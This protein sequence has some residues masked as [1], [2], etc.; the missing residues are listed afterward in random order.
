MWVY[1]IGAFFNFN[2]NNVIQL[3][4]SEFPRRT[5]RYTSIHSA[6]LKIEI[7]HNTTDRIFLHQNDDDY[8]LAQ[9]FIHKNHLN[10]NLVQHIYHKI[11]FSR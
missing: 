7:D 5:N 4:P 1:E 10:T 11:A 2:N 9:H 8:R 6:V 3:E